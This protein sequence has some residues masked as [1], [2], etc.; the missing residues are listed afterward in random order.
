M[1]SEHYDLVLNRH[2]KETLV[3]QRHGVASTRILANLK[4]R[5]ALLT[6]ADWYG[7]KSL[8]GRHQANSHRSFSEA[9]KA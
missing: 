9:Y 5:L 1:M 6:D 7:V 2:L 8:P 3:R 4:I